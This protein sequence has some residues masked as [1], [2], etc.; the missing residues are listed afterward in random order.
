MSCIWMSDTH[1]YK[2]IWIYGFLIFACIW[3]YLCRSRYGLANMPIWSDIAVL[4]VCICLY[5]S[6]TYSNI[7]LDMKLISACIWLYLP[8]STRIFCYIRLYQPINVHGHG[9]RASAA[10]TAAALPLHGRH[11]GRVYAGGLPFLFGLGLQ[12]RTA[13]SQR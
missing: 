7:C 2:Q 9:G 10:A 1:T 13:P 8:V 3:L 5:F 6:T 11:A 12:D 4:I